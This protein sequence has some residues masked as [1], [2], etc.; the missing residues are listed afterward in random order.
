[1]IATFIFIVK[2]IVILNIRA[3]FVQKKPLLKAAL[4]H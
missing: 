1:M 2:N 4:G 3:L